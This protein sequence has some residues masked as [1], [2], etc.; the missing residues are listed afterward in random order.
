MTFRQRAWHAVTLFIIV[1]TCIYF[2]GDTM[3]QLE[4]WGF[5][6]GTFAVL[7]GT[8]QLRCIASALEKWNT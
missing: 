1:A 4:A 7:E 2:R 5:S 8:W 3:T 6:L